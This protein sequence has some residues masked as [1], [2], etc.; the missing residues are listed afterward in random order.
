M[1]TGKTRC[2]TIR[3]IIQQHYKRTGKCKFS[4]K[5]KSSYSSIIIPMCQH[6]VVLSPGIKYPK[7]HNPKCQHWKFAA[8]DFW[9]KALT[10]APR[11]SS[12]SAIAWRK[13][14]RIKL[15]NTWETDWSPN[16][17]DGN[18]HRIV[19][20]ITI[21]A[22]KLWH[23]VEPTTADQAKNVTKICPNKNFN[24]NMSRDEWTYQ[25]M[26]LTFATCCCKCLR[27][28]FL[29]QSVC[30]GCTYI[31]QPL[32]QVCNFMIALLSTWVCAFLMPMCGS[33]TIAPYVFNSI[34]IQLSWKTKTASK[35]WNHDENVPNQSHILAEH[36]SCVHVN[37]I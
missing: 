18:K 12:S 33:K 21:P 29:D 3:A 32:Y 13:K 24:H 19:Q 15:S 5:A 2:K 9:M 8:C 10:P 11:I 35:N 14:I 4:V 23:F 17:F 30:V 31:L 26:N 25:V 20:R 34:C 36:K 6:P 27:S 22:S 16:I 28:I 1:H 37:L 7:F